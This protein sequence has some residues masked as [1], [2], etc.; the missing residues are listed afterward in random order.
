[1]TTVNEQLRSVGINHHIYLQR[2][3]RYE[4]QQIIDVLNQVDKELADRIVV[5]LAGSFTE[6]RLERLSKDIKVIV[7][8]ALKEITNKQRE[9]ITGFLKV[10]TQW[11]ADQLERLL[12]IVWNIAQPSPQQIW[13]AANSRPFGSPGNPTLLTDVWHDWGRVKAR[14]INN[15]LRKGFVEGKTV[16]EMARAIRGTKAANFQDGILDIDRNGAQSIVRTAVSHMASVAREMVYG[17]NQDL[18]AGVQ[19]VATLDGHTTIICMSLDGKVDLFDGSQVELN[20]ERPPAHWGCRSTTVPVVKSWD[21]LGI[22]LEEAPAGTRASM[23]GQVADT[24]TYGSWLAKQPASFQRDILGSSRYDL[25][26]GGMSINQFVDD[27]RIL[28]LKELEDK[29]K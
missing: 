2:W 1:M 21:E 27:G 29:G 12:P 7:A 5:K 26:K 23:N 15:V 13:S 20:G 11:Q 8:D 14:R 28:T 18:I 19:W 22:D 3:T 17:E 25:Y 4:I 10:E 6:A 24:E 16:D 9:D